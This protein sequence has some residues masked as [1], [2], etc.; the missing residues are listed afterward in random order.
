MFFAITLNLLF[1]CYDFFAHLPF[2]ANSHQILWIMNILCEGIDSLSQVNVVAALVRSEAIFAL[3]PPNLPETPLVMSMGVIFAM[4]VV[5]FWLVNCSKMGSVFLRNRFSPKWS[6]FYQA[7][8]CKVTTRKSGFQI[9]RKFV[10]FQNVK[11]GSLHQCLRGKI[12]FFVSQKCTNL[13]MSFDAK[14]TPLADLT[15]EAQNRP[16]CTLLVTVK[17]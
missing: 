2:E 9:F 16:I 4:I 7:C 10:A 8:E 11:I 17:K 12:Y 5:F 14:M 1:L 6:V 3:S 15:I 13:E